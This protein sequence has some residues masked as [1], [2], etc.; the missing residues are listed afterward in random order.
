MWIDFP[1]LKTTFV[2][3]TYGYSFKYL[4]RGG[5]TP[6]KVRWDP[7]SAAPIAEAGV[8]SIGRDVDQFD[9]VDTGLAAMF[10]GASMEIPDGLIDL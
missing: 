8:S 9:V 6:A 3:P 4:D 10:L 5:L 2:S 1:N 7:V